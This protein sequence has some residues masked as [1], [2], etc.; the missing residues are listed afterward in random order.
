MK[1]LL[2]VLSLCVFV[3]GCDDMSKPAMD[4]I[5]D[6][7]TPAEEST[8]QIP[9]PIETTRAEIPKIT[10]ENVQDLQ[11]GRYRVRPTGYLT[12]LELGSEAIY[13]IRWGNVDPRGSLVYREDLPAEAPK[14]SLLLH[15]NRKPYEL[16]VDGKPIIGTE[17][18][19]VI[20]V[21]GPA[22]ER[23][24]V[25]GIR[26]E[27][28]TYT[29]IIYL[30]NLVE[31]LDRPDIEIEFVESPV[32][33][34]PQETPEHTGEPEFITFENALDLQPG[35]RY[36]FRPTHINAVNSHLKDEAWVNTIHWGNV[37]Y[38][39]PFQRADFPDDAPKIAL[40]IHPN[41]LIYYYTPD[42]EP[43]IEH[44]VEGVQ[45]LSDEIV[46]EIEKRHVI[47]VSTGGE[48]AS[49]FEFHFVSYIGSVIEN[50]TNPDLKFE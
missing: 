37:L 44:A 9:P 48:K 12:H 38:K 17:D 20:D 46:V 39:E 10:F 28:F 31:N 13:A 42:G 30:V 36:R 6:I 2:I 3:I 23:H 5:G 14:I 1:K 35:N 21:I 4:V 32:V 7:V 29:S 8:I 49:Q 27:T 15:I 25:G 19:V 33:P 43:V 40:R 45:G 34:E 22:V 47:T 41:H 16:T 24:H 50:L 11:P 26:G 18:E